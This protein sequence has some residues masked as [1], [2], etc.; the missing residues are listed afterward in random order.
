MPHKD[1]K[2]VDDPD[3][4]GLHRN[5]DVPLGDNIIS[6]VPLPGGAGKSMREAA[7][8]IP[9]VQH[10][11]N[12]HLLFI[13]RAKNERD[14][15]SGQ[16]AFPGGAQDAADHSLQATA[17]REAQEEIGLAAERINLL[18]QLEPYITISHYRVTAI[19][20]VV[21]WPSELILQTSEV[22]RAFL[23]PLAWLR[24]RS[25]FSMRARQDMD[26]H[27]ARRHPIIVF[28]EYDGE[29]LWGATARMT[30]NFI[31]TLDEQQI[32]LPDV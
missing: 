25:N 4:V 15:H 12:W 20:G 13:R 5:S 32:R 22:A 16:V 18:G 6:G 29:T 17:L 23:I 28:S 8:L 19:V 10:D 24:E 7:V 3:D 31:R 21:Q 9:L 30:V 27:S 14:R 11:A 26:P 1:F 2:K